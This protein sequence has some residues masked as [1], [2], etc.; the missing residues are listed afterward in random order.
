MDSYRAL[1]VA[2]LV[3]LMVIAG[4]GTGGGYNPNNVTVTVSPAAVTIP[5]NGQVTLQATVNGLCSTCTSSIQYW[6]IAEDPDNSVNCTWS[7]M[8]PTGPCPGGTIQQIPGGLSS[9]LTVTYYAPSTPGTFQ[10]SAAWCIC[11]TPA[12]IKQGMSV[13]TV[14]P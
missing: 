6:S 4:C 1:F 9:S 14:S 10:V 5:A 11:F 7:T 12:I 13:I 8:P 2:S 3:L